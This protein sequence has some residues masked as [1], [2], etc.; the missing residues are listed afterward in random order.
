MY[1]NQIFSRSELPVVSAASS[2]G[3]DRVLGQQNYAKY[4]GDHDQMMTSRQRQ[5]NDTISYGDSPNCFH[6]FV[7]F[8]FF[9]FMSSFKFVFKNLVFI[10]PPP[11]N[12]FQRF[13]T[14]LGGLSL[15]GSFEGKHDE[16]FYP[17]NQENHK[18]IS[19]LKKVFKQVWVVSVWGGAEQNLG[20]GGG[21]QNLGGGKGF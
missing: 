18:K 20:G 8:K 16:R 19:D 9:L 4:F 6:I 7:I 3:C 5:K 11:S 10:P 2:S 21:E 1:E 14:G 15:S 12:S 13:Q 17:V